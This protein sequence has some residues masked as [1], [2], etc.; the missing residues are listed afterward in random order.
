MKTVGEILKNKR[1]ERK[2][3]LEE[4]QQ[5]TKIKVSYLEAVEKNDF[6][7]IPGGAPIA[8]GFIRNY[9]ELLGLSSTEV[10]AVFRRDFQESK[11]GEIIPHGYYEPLNQPRLTWNPKLTV[12][13]G[14]A[15][16]FFSLTGY[17]FYQV[18]SS[19]GKPR[20]TLYAPQE[21]TVV[22]QT[23][24]EVL[25]KSDPDASVFVNSELITIDKEGNFG[26]KVNLFPG[27]NKIQIEAI[28]RRGKKA[29]IIRRII[30]ES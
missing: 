7:K 12:F 8:K 3:T 15:I 10:L 13:L 23:E 26:I 27:E 17:L 9:A 11:T 4:A 20:L 1:L 16:L 5:V 19:I 25:G 14:L 29:E 28:S 24:I 6:G 2:L 18:F 30:Q 21:G 22:R